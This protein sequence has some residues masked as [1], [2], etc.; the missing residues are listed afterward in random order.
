MRGE[1]KFR[2]WSEFGFVAQAQLLRKWVSHVCLSANC[3]YT[4]TILIVQKRKSFLKIQIQKK[5]EKGSDLV[6]I[7]ALV[8]YI[9][10]W[11]WQ[12]VEDELELVV[13]KWWF[14]IGFLCFS[15]TYFSD[16]L[17][18]ISLLFTKIFLWFVKMHSSEYVKEQNNDNNGQV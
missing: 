3:K 14:S 17:K 9:A 1:Q 10:C 15:Q 4:N 8:A 12:G 18:W 2:S 7:F 5:T 11:K 6:R 13:E 16:Y